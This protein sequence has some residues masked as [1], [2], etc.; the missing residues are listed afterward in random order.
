M[1]CFQRTSEASDIQHLINKE[2]FLIIVIM[3]S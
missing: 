2:G 3:T 1:I